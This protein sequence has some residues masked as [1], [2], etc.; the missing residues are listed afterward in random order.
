MSW[1]TKSLVLLPLGAVLVVA[2]GWWWGESPSAQRQDLPTLVIAEHR[3]ARIQALQ[4]L[5]P[6]LEAEL[7][8][9]LKIVEYPAPPQ[10]YFTKL[11]TELRAGNAPD[12]FTIPRDL[13]MDDL[14]AAG[15]LANLTDAVEQWP[16]YQHLPELVKQLTRASFDEQVYV[17]PSIVAVEQLY[18]R[19]DLLTAAGISTAQPQSWQDLLSR[20]RQIKQ[21]LGQY[22]L[23]IPAGLTWGM[24]SYTEGFRYLLASFSDYQLLNVDNQYVLAG[25]AVHASFG[26][27]QTL[28]QQQLMPV[29]PLLNPEPWVI[30]KYEM[31]PKGQLLITTCGSWCKVFDWGPDS[32]NPIPNV[33]QA[34]QT[35][36]FPSADGGE[37]F[38][39]A[40]VV[41]SWGVNAKSRQQQLAQQLVLALGEVDVAL[42]YAEKLGNVPARLDAAQH[43]GF[44]ALGSRMEDHALLPQARAL[45]TTVGSNAMMAGVAQASEAVLTGRS[46]AGQAQQQLIDYV[47]NVLGDQQV[48]P[49]LTV[50][51]LP[52][53]GKQ[54]D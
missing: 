40:S 45:R 21:Q 36:K 50:A 10:D 42:V 8:V 30:P 5:K 20:S 17:V 16:G 6:A 32:R 7:G 1:T 51:A 43:P 48:K 38:A 35:W 37:P 24:G 12:V 52:K 49:Q 44:A 3:T 54:H 31:F 22:P 46:D 14:A 33:D 11:V 4:Q 27:Y 26:F 41:Y 23:L 28:V 9:Y 47:T 18:Y 29:K 25:E 34:V 13:Q 19:H 39:L 2:V 53:G 15:Y